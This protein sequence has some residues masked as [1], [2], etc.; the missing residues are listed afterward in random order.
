MTK[1]EFYSKIIEIQRQQGQGISGIIKVR[2][3]LYTQ[4][5]DE[6]IEEGLIVACDTGVTIGHPESNIFYVPTKGYNVWLDEG[7]D[8]YY[9]RYK[10]RYLEFV[11]FYLGISEHPDLFEDLEVKK[12]YQEWLNRNK[13][14]LLEMVNLDDSY[15]VSTF[16]S[17]EID[18]IKSSKWYVNSL[19]TKDC[20][21]EIKKEL[22]YISDYTK[23]SNE[24][25]RLYKYN[26]DKYQSS[27]DEANKELDQLKKEKKIWIKL[28]GILKSSDHI[29]KLED[30]L[31]N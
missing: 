4:Y 18:F 22:D 14:A 11:R 15:S 24:L 29:T 2:S 1:K 7:T 28:E 25:I 21:V 3:Q 12:D 9:S 10:G 16:T 26:L 8:G 31:K 6:L 17:D 20:L 5:L 30:V 27:L 13:E 19:T 23:T